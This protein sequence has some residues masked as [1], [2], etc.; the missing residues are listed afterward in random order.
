MPAAATSRLAVQTIP[1]VST[2]LFQFSHRRS[3]GQFFRGLSQRT[4]RRFP[5]D[6]SYGLLLL[7]MAP[8]C[9]LAATV[10]SALGV[11][12]GARLLFLLSHPRALAA[13]SFPIFTLFPA[14]RR[15]PPLPPLRQAPQGRI[16][17]CVAHPPRGC[18]AAPCCVPHQH[19]GPRNP[20]VR[21]GVDALGVVVKEAV[22]A[23]EVAA[24]VGGRRG[25]CVRFLGYSNSEAQVGLLDPG[26]VGMDGDGRH[27]ERREGSDLL[28][29]AVPVPD[30]TH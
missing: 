27:F 9:K 6:L 7:A 15:T 23:S 8:P 11:A 19:H 4:R 29:L 28:C 24:W 26:V 20:K 1:F 10:T 12:V 30:A 25:R 14:G 2:Y 22:I 3:A 21:N 16:C 18:L 5:V 13:A 17:R